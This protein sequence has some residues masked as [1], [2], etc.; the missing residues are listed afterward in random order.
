MRTHGAIARSILESL[1]FKYRWTLNQLTEIIGHRI[2]TIHIVGGGS[3]NR[4]LC[5]FT[6]NATGLPVVAGPVEATAVGNILAQAM[7]AGLIKSPAQARAV[8]RRSFPLETY[9]PIDRDQWSEKYQIFL[10][11]A[12]K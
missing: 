1:A 11:I 4:L 6:A 3:R 12:G 9:A 8:V 5:Q 7:A 10:A 2:Q